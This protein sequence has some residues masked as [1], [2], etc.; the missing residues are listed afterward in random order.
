MHFIRAACAALAAIFAMAPP[1]AFAQIIPAPPVVEAG[2][3]TY[4]LFLRGA[5]IGSEQINVTRAAEG[6]TIVSSGRLGAPIDVV[7]R[8]VQARY[9][10]DWIPVELSFD[11][12][13][14]GQQQSIRTVIEGTTAKT[15]IRIA[16][17]PTEKSDTI[18]A[19]GVLVLPNSFFG[20][21][22]ALAARLRTASPG[23]TI[24]VYAVP[25]GSFSVRV[26]DSAPEQIQTAG[27]MVSTRRTHMTLMLQ[28][29]ALDAD[30]W[31]DQSGR[32]VRISIPL[33][34]VEFV[35]EDVAAVSS[36]TVPISRP[37]DEPVKIPGNGFVLAGTLSRPTSSAETRLAAVVLVGGSGPTDR[38]EMMYGV[39]VLGQIA[40]A[41]AE[42]GF[43]VLRYD[44]RGIGQSGGRAEAASLADFAE[45]VRAAV[46]WLSDRK[47]VDAKRIAVAG[48]SDG[49]TVALMAAAREKRI[50]AAVVL[51][52]SGV[53]G[54]ELVLAQQQR[55][56]SRSKMTAEEQQ[57]KVDLQKR[58]HEAV[59]TGKGWDQLPADV[60]RQV[61]NPEYQSILLNDP[62]K[63]MPNVKQPILIVQGE[64]DTQVEPANADKLEAL[65]RKRKNA[66]PVDVVKVP[67][68]NHL[69]VPAKTGEVD[70]YG[71]LT[72][73][74]VSANVTNAIVT[75]L[76]KTLSVTR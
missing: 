75:W 19:D 13:V 70:E 24:P 23:A 56:L 63:V 61:D 46:K 9:T 71:T 18:A 55:V 33:Q 14:R 26:G 53:T 3:T 29:A 59:I 60:R 36:R 72:D 66:P 17:Q 1:T 48:H 2:G 22:E 11:G 54:A 39:P 47:D 27:G 45:D 43:I 40:N 69:L 58:I 42:A 73:K 38:D 12:T 49:G 62:S 8:R 25:Q 6:W 31:T 74:Q 16:G 68:V 21:Y 52:T 10:P 57:A 35:R 44:K 34:G 7:G 28:G 51:G 64:L 65:A 32:L 15:E 67:G 5:P 30:L 76:K 37:N 4:R 20:P 41:L 50:A